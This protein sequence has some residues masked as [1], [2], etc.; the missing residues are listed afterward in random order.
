M[1]SQS[2]QKGASFERWVCRELS[3]WLTN[4]KREDLF[5]R[6]A[7]SGGRSTIYARRGEELRAAAQAGD[8]SGVDEVGCA[9]VN[10]YYIEC[11]F[12]KYLNIDSLFFEFS[13][14][15]LLMFW[16]QSRKHASVLGKRTMLIAKQ[17]YKPALM[18]LEMNALGDFFEDQKVLDELMVPLAV[19][20]KH[21]LAVMPF[22]SFLE[23][24][25]IPPRFR[26]HL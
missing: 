15:G 11:K 24:A 22:D 23:C 4:G 1:G 17:N 16:N 13:G 7:M 8:I 6:S 12:Y 25:A 10:D 3:K 14:S 9:F 18:C 5:W 19:F 26:K 21:E 20:W 2:K